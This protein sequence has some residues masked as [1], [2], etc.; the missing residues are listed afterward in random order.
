MGMTSHG[1]MALRRGVL[2]PRAETRSVVMGCNLPVHC[3][4]SNGSGPGLAKSGRTVA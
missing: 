3:G 1:Q 2:C 4:C